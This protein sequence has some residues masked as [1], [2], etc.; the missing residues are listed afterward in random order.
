LL[1][2]WGRANSTNVKKVLWCAEE[3]GLAYERIEAGGAF[4]VVDTPAY[5]ALNPNRTVP[6]I[7]DDG[8]VLWE[9]N[10]IVR[11]LAA[12]YAPGRLHQTDVVAQARADRWM[13]W[14]ST[15]LVPKFAVLFWGLLR[16]AP[17]KRDM[18][19]IEQAREAVA[20]FLAIADAALADQPYLSGEQFGVGDIPLGCIAYAWFNLPLERPA[21]ANLQRWYDS[22]VARPAYRSAVMTPL[23]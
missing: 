10:A 20:G 13:D 8:L 12:R 1:R 21:A 14:A 17:E 4:G 7:E 22:L 5:A 9:S 11:Y 2:V 16:T 6:T 23:S 3:A 18:A 15:T 19:A